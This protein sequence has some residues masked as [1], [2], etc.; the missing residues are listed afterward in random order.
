MLHHDTGQ[1]LSFFGLCDC[2][3][4]FG[5]CFSMGGNVINTKEDDSAGIIRSYLKI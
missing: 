4:D 5:I 2:F 3:H 1:V